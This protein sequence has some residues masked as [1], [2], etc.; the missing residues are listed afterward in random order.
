MSEVIAK[1]EQDPHGIDQHA[2]GAKLDQGKTLAGEIIIAFPRAM[3]SLVRVATYGAGKYSRHGFL[4]VPDAEL[5]YLD[6]AIR[7]LLKYGAGE[8]I[9]QESLLPHIDHVLW[10]I[11]AIVEIGKR[12]EEKKSGG[13]IR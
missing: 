6:A 7:H 4:V 10:N 8:K 12:N 11:A 13:E 9:D 1:C 2:P 3:E 5:R